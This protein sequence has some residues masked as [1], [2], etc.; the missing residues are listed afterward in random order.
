M[1]PHRLVYLEDGV[2]APELPEPLRASRHDPPPQAGLILP[3][4]TDWHFHWVQM[5]IAGKAKAGEMGLLP[6]LHDVAWPAEERFG[7]LA[8]CRATVPEALRRLDAAGTV[9]GAAYASP[10]AASAEAFLERAH[11]GFVCGPAVMTTGEPAA[12]LRP[13]AAAMQDLERLHARFVNRLVVTPRFALSCDDETL[14]ALG[15]FASERGL[16]VQTHLSEQTAEVETVRNRFRGDADYLAVYERAGLVGPRTLLAH[17]IHVSDGELERIARA[18]ATVVHCPSSN[19]AL[20]SG[21]MPLERLRRAGVPWVLGSDVGAGPELCMLDAI[22]AALDQHQG[23]APVTAAELLHHATLSLAAVLGGQT[24]H[25]GGCGV[26]AG[27]IVVA[28]PDG[29][30]LRATDAASLLDALLD[31]WRRDRRFR[32]RRVEPWPV[33]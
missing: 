30:D 20:G 12:L 18:G 11:D 17:T 10:H 22:C 29:I 24:L 31:A 33:A 19:R 15:R 6:W 7:D 5:G 27:A 3:G 32:V 8:R 4:F 25:A 28:P 23:Q 9:G 1:G 2:V 13:L 21:R 14:A 26:R 16:I